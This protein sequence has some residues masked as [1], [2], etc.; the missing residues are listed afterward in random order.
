[1]NILDLI[2]AIPLAWFTYKGFKRGLIF[3]VFSF[4]GLVAG[5]ILAVHLSKTLSQFIN[6]DGPFAVLAAFFLIF[7]GVVLLSRLVGRL[8]EKAV[9]LVHMSLLNNLAGALLG[10]LK[11]TVILSVLIYYVNVID[12]RQKLL[13]QQVKEASL[14]YKPVDSAGNLLIGTLKAYVAQKKEECK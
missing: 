4:A 8:C 14:F 9:K 7:V 11:C 3:E 5:C 1:M 10:I 12:F 13:P 2:L 6:A